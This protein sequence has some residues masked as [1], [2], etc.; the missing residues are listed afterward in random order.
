MKASRNPAKLRSQPMKHCP[1]CDT[2]YGLR[3]EGTGFSPYIESPNSA[4]PLG[5]EGT[6]PVAQALH[7]TRQIAADQGEAAFFSTWKAPMCEKKITAAANLE[8]C[9]SIST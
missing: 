6:L 1:Q 3:R 4:W 5:P 8:E 9:L 7:L 2:G